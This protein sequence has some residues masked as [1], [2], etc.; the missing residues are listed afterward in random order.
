MNK[1]DARLKRLHKYSNPDLK[2]LIPIVD[3]ALTT[4][5]NGAE[6]EY[7]VTIGNFEDSDDMLK[8]VGFIR[9]WYTAFGWTV[10]IEFAGIGLDSKNPVALFES[11]AILTFK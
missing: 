8:T 6:E 5:P 7:S 3:S 10:S 9:D 1:T 11:K 2:A 4:R